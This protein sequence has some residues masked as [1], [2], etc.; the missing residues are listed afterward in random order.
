MYRVHPSNLTLGPFL[1]L[2]FT[3]RRRSGKSKRLAASGKAELPAI[4][5]DAA[6]AHE[7]ALQE[8]IADNSGGNRSPLILGPFLTLILT[9]HCS[10]R[11]TSGRANEPA[12]VLGRSPCRR[13]S[14]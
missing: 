12:T 14:C 8:F 4:G 5:N 9:V 3:L 10:R 2:L 6:N 1:T 13:P 11:R 7:G